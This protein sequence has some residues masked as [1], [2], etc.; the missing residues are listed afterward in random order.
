MRRVLIT[1]ASGFLGRP[2]LQALSD[3]GYELH[4]V[5]RQPCSELTGTAC[6]HYLDLRDSVQV[7]ALVHK[8]KPQELIHLAWYTEPGRFFTDPVNVD[9]LQASITLLQA[10]VLSGGSRALIAGTCAEYDWRHGSC[11]ED[12][13]PL[14]PNTVYGKCKHALF[15]VAAAVAET[16]GLSVVWPRLFFLYGPFENP[17]RFVSSMITDLL[18]GR[19]AECRQGRL[20]RDYMFAPDAGKALAAL[21]QSDFE[22]AV[23]VATGESVEL[24]TIATQISN[25]LGVPRL[26]RINDVEP[27]GRDRIVVAD[28]QRLTRVLPEWTP[29]ELNEGLSETL[30]WWRNEVNHRQRRSTA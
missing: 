17:K 22:G 23:N 15:N 16:S 8:V 19:A 12:V 6:W 27:S 4:A 29:A 18:A 2:V 11:V 28:T 21:L 25:M 26:L 24:G 5:A 3:Q 14:L 9:W 10:F 7:E 20:Q 30:A 13:T 1:G